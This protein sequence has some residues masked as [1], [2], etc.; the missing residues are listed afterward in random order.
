M[1]RYLWVVE[2]KEGGQWIATAWTFLSRKEARNCAQEM[3]D[4]FYEQTRIV[5]YVPEGK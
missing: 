1:K 5:K 3:R 2:M 4:G